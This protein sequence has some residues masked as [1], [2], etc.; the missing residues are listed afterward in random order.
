MWG[1][2]MK[3]LNGLELTHE[4]ATNPNIQPKFIVNLF[5]FDECEYDENGKKI[6]GSDIIFVVKKTEWYED[7]AAPD[8]NRWKGV[9]ETV[10]WAST[11]KPIK[12]FL[13]E[14]QEFIEIN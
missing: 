5:D 9:G 7:M 14:R 1:D 6:P 12:K 13:K 8:L 11:K 2:M 3:N 4:Q 10:F